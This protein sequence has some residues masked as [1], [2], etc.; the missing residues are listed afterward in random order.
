MD[1][2]IGSNH[3]MVEGSEIVV[4]RTFAG[5]RELVFSLWTTAEHLKQWWGPRIYPTTYCTVDFRP[6][7]VWH[8]CMTGPNGDQSWG[9]STYQEIVV[10][11]RIVYMDAFSD[12]DGNVTADMPQMRIVITFADVDGGTKVTSTAYAGSAEEVQTLLNMGMAEGIAETWDRLEEL[13][14]REQA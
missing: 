9:K 10:P 12:A 8:Y 2:V 11:E 14:A 13:I 5:P 3:V 4:E 1:K 6:G 7:G